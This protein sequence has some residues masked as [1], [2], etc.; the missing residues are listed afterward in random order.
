MSR[1][2]KPSISVYDYPEHLNPF[3]DDEKASKDAR[4]TVNGDAKLAPV[5]EP[6]SKFWTFGRSR[7]KRSNS[8]SIKSTWS[9]LF[10]KRKEISEIPE[11]TTAIT[12][13]SSAYKTERP[14]APPRVSRDQQEFDE[15]LGTLVRRR[16]YTLDNSSRY[17]SSLTVNGD[18]ARL[19]D[20]TPQDT[21]TSIMGDLTP[22]APA[23]RFGQVSPRPKDKIP[24][25][26]FEDKV[27]RENGAIEERNSE[28]T[29]VP[30]KRNS[31]RSS[32]RLNVTL[33]SEEDFPER[34][35]RSNDVSLRDENENVAD[36]YVF[37]RFSQ[38]AVRRSN[39][40]INSCISV[41]STVSAYGRKKRRAPQPP[42]RVEQLETPREN[43][44]RVLDVS[45][46]SKS[47]DV[48]DIARVTENIDEMTKKS[49]EAGEGS[50]STPTK[51]EET[52]Q[53]DEQQDSGETHNPEVED[54]KSPP[55]E[56]P[57]TLTIDLEENLQDIVHEDVPSGKSSPTEVE[58]VELRKVEE[59]NLEI[60]E[61]SIQAVDEVS[62]RKRGSSGALSRSDSFSVKEE[63]EKIEKQIKAL[64][65]RSPSEENSSE[66]ISG[67]RLSIQANRRS[68]F[69]NMMDDKEI[70][71]EMKEVPRSSNDVEVVRLPEPPIPVE[72]SLEPVKVIELHISEPIRR[73]PEILEDVNPVPKPRRNSAQNSLRSSSRRGSAETVQVDKRGSSF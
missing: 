7:K 21:T 31:Q 17:G 36:D 63:I 4:T 11:R 43:E 6:K 26:D 8:F 60:I 52:S 47:L 65:A 56:N 19:Y 13:V 42:R 70:K 49:L 48:G 9:G 39:L 67:T 41:S 64:E 25:L 38:D 14:V 68:F 62:L 24:P 18:P 33:D 34:A 61:E 50:S 46:D 16:K 37:K 15:A 54:S 71:V 45:G 55:G 57:E 22:K 35:S 72:A 5:K 40:S 3:K 20:G 1:L 27:H 32:L 53:K 69:K 66:E 10:G 58:E 44:V 29:P 2:R 51:E 28:L 30:P 12:T 73:R 59:E 23:R